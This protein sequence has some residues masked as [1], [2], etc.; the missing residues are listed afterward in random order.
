MRCVVWIVFHE[1]AL[2]I[3][4]SRSVVSKKVVVNISSNKTLF[5]KKNK[6]EMEAAIMERKEEFVRRFL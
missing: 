2:I 4:I 1:I 5:S 6:R 3:K